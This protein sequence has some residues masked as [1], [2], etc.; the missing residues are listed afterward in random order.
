MASLLRNVKLSRIDLVDAPANP[1]ARVLLVKRDG[2]T[3]TLETPLPRSS[4]R[5]GHVN[6]PLAKFIKKM[7]ALFKE[8]EQQSFIPKE[9]PGPGTP[10]HEDAEMSHI[11]A[12]AQMHQGLA[13]AIEGFGDSATLPPEH[14]VHALKALHAAIGDHLA[15][16]ADAGPSGDIAMRDAGLN[17]EDVKKVNEIVEK[18]VVDFEKRAK[19]AE[20]RATTAETIA[21]AERDT[22]ELGEVIVDLKKFQNVAIDVTKEAPLFKKMR[23]TDPELYTSMIAK[24]TAANETVKLAKKLETDLGSGQPGDGGGNAWKEIEAEA[25]KLLTKGEVGL[26]KEKAINRVMETR[27]DL[28][29]RYYDEGGKNDPVA[30]TVQ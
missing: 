21:K 15:K 7:Q 10:G 19:D 13:K 28:V 9:G 30:S 26:T 20:A 27:H 29:K 23:D 18:R 3:P 25:E 17:D 12:L 16:T 11:D 8:G 2:T 5:S 4:A 6:E 24:L 1:G 22:R 14:P